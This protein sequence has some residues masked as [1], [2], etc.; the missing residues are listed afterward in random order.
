MFLIYKVAKV[1]NRSY[2]LKDSV[3][4]Y[5]LKVYLNVHI[6]ESIFNKIVLQFYFFPL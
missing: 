2:Q 6:I 4:L 5:R 1:I 3:Y